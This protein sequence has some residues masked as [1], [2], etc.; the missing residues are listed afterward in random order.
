MEIKRTKKAFEEV[1]SVSEI[2]KAVKGL[3]TFVVI[4]GFVTLVGSAVEGQNLISDF[5]F[6]IKLKKPNLAIEDKI[7]TQDSVKVLRDK[8]HIIYDP[9]GS[10]GEHIDIYDLVAVKR[11]T[12]E[13]VIPDYIFPLFAAAPPEAMLE[14][15]GLGEAV[16][17]HRQET[18]AKLLT[19]EGQSIEMY[20]DILAEARGMVKPKTFILAG[21]LNPEGIIQVMDC[22]RWGSTELIKS[23]EMDRQYFLDKFSWTAHIQKFMPEL[24]MGF[25]EAP[26]KERVIK[27]IKLEEF[28]SNL[29]PEDFPITLEV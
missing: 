17:I 29:K 10:H 18:E 14:D 9:A 23:S 8:A 15:I 28:L 1:E 6:V 13:K 20:P 26:F 22:F 7:F 2:A 4:P 21:Y 5:D 19:P 25:P 27:K 16:Y 11:Q 24:E 12:F 3:K